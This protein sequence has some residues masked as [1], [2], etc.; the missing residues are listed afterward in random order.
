LPYGHCRRAFSQSIQNAHYVN[1][2]IQNVSYAFQ[3][4]AIDKKT[5]IHLNTLEA[6]LLI[7]GDEV[8]T[9][10]SRQYLCYVMQAFNTFVL[11]PHLTINLSF[12]G[13]AS[14]P[15]LW[16]PGKKTMMP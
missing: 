8:Q 13:P 14:R 3:Q 10:K 7:M 4:V 1:I 2:L 6:A 9:L 5:N 11:L 15:M 12:P 16:E